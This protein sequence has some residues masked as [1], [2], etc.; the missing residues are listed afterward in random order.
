MPP[1]AWSLP[2]AD[3]GA[4]RLL[5]PSGDA[6]AAAYVIPAAREPHLSR[7]R[8][9]ALLGTKVKYVFVLFQENR[10]FDFCYGS[11]PGVDGLYTGPGDPKPGFTQSLENPDGSR[12]TVRPFRVGPGDYAADLDDVGHAHG[13]MGDKMDLV[14]GVPRMDHFALAEEEKHAKGGAPSLKDKQFGELTMAH[15]DGDTIPFLWR[16]ANRFVVCDHVFQLIVG[17]STPGAISVLAAQTGQ[18]QAALHPEELAKGRGDKGPGEPVLNDS[19]PLWG[20]SGDSSAS[21]PPVNPED[22]AGKDKDVAYNQTYASL[23]LS[24]AGS[25]AASRTSADPSKAG[26]LKDVGADLAALSRGGQPAFSWGWYQEGYGGNDHSAYV[27]HHNG[28]QYF[29]YIMHSP[30]MASSIH[31][32]KD[33]FPDLERGALSKAGGVYYVR[34]GKRNPFG[35]APA[36]PELAARGKFLGDDDHPG[37]ADSDS[38]I[39]EALLARS[40]NAIARSR[41]WPQ[42]AIIITYDESGGWYDHVPPPVRAMGPGKLVLGDGPRIPLLVISPFARAHTVLSEPGDHGSV[43]KFADAVFGLT[44]LAR[45]P[46]E[47][48]GRTLGMKQWQQDNWGPDDAITQGVSDLVDALDPARLAG[49]APSLPPSYAIIPDSVVDRL[50]RASGYGLKDIGVVPTDLGLPDSVPADFNPRPETDPTQPEQE[51]K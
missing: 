30:A 7:K 14:D 43:I 18:T 1:A 16:W 49:R 12:T 36:D 13:L 15:V 44:P 19:D 17:P 22:F 27:T 32:L 5:P 50:P 51:A 37:A 10:S 46:D 24:L 35:M 25:Q 9:L 2:P 11:F 42:C 48:K 26:D 39:A 20:S 47:L 8:L 3:S 33:F 41:Y 28:A 23:P 40:V 45:L 38:Q 34:G 31:D 6:Q 29:G 21:K 4:V